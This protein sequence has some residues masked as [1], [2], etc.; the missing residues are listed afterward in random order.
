[1]KPHNVAR[2]SIVQS[3]AFQLSREL[4]VPVVEGID[5][6]GETNDLGIPA[7]ELQPVGAPA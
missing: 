6:E 5:D 4:M 7:G 1:M 3:H 2:P